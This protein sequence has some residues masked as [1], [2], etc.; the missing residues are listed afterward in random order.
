MSYR[1]R[2]GFYHIDFR[3]RERRYRVSTGLED[4][5]ENEQFVADWDAAIRREIALGTFRLENH[6]PKLAAPVLAE[7]TFRQKAEAWL[8]AHQHSWAEWTY[9]KFKSNLEARIFT[10]GFARLKI[11]EIKPGDLRL[12]QSELIE[13]GRQDGKGRLSNRAVNKLMQPVKAM[14]C[15]RSGSN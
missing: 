12:L 14:L 10:K 13:E 3:W 2:D 6:F 9:R 8:K 4:T 1:R 7:G 15:R 5:P 11:E